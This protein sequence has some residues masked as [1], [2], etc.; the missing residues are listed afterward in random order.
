[1][2]LIVR[3]ECGILI[4]SDAG[5]LQVQITDHFTRLLK[6]GFEPFDDLWIYTTPNDAVETAM[7]LIE[8]G[9]WKSIALSGQDKVKDHTWDNRAQQVLNVLE[10][11]REP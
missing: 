7:Y 1:M 2:L 10:A 8:S 11:S 6:L 3:D 9:E 4:Q 5:D